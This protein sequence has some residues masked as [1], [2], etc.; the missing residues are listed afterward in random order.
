MDKNGQA[1]SEFQ[2]D[3]DPSGEPRKLKNKYLYYCEAYFI[4]C[5]VFTNGW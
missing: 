4:H 3:G 5:N 1:E 2:R